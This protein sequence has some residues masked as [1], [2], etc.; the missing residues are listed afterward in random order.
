M[1]VRV[2]G[3]WWW[4]CNN[5]CCI[6][7]C[8]QA[9]VCSAQHFW[10][11]TWSSRTSQ[12]RFACRWTWNHPP[13][14]N[15]CADLSWE[16]R[17]CGP[18]A[19]EAHNQNSENMERQTLESWRHVLCSID[20]TDAYLMVWKFVPLMGCNLALVRPDF[21]WVFSGETGLWEGVCIRHK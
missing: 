17:C 2:W 13:E 1:W 18:N 11:W 15:G 6:W 16:L 20:I 9:F 3:G 8:S 21:H 4:R 12:T 14:G 10:A 7:W 19:K 5:Q